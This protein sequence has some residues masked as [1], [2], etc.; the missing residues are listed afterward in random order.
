MVRQQLEA[1]EIILGGAIERRGARLA[2]VDADRDAPPAGRGLPGEAAG[3]GL[4]AVVVETHA[5]DH[6]LV[7][8]V[9]EHARPVVPRLVQQG[10]RADLDVT[11]AERRRAAPRDAV[12]VK[13]RGQPDRVGKAEAETLDRALRRRRQLGPGFEHAPHRPA[14]SQPRE[15]LH[16]PLVG[17]LRIEPEQDG[18]DEPFVDEAHGGETAARAAKT[19]APA[20]DG[21]S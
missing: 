16:P 17:H 6:R 2:E 1:A 18:A 3:H 15:R 20:M 14:P 12:L 5:I 11:E 21:G 8:R 13:A 7:R 10:H 9:A 4:G 19:Q